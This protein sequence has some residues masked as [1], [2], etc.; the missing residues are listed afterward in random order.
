MNSIIRGA[1]ASAL[2]GI[3]AFAV[4]EFAKQQRAKQGSV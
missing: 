4:I 1:L 3:I 2:G